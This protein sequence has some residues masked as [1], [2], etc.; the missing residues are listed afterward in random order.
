MPLDDLERRQAGIKVAGQ[1]LNLARHLATVHV[2]R[3]FYVEAL[4][5]IPKKKKR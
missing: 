5:G 1:C 2:P 4:P 3:R